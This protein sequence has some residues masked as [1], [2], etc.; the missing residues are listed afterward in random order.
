M[1]KTITAI[2]ALS[3]S[4]SKKLMSALPVVNHNR[5]FAFAKNTQFPS[6]LEEAKFAL[7]E[8]RLRKKVYSSFGPFPH[9]ACCH[10]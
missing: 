3:D 8:R 6:F 4:L 7:V 1:S 5:D 9:M 2:L 10:T